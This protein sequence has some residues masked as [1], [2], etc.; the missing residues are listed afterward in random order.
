MVGALEI[1]AHFGKKRL[2]ERYDLTGIGELSS[3]CGGDQTKF[4]LR[5]GEHDHDLDPAG[6]QR[7]IVEERTHFGRGPRISIDG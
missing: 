5:L 7:G 2:V 3:R 4:G 6:G 1:F